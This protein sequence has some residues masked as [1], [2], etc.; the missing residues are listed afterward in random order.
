MSVKSLI[1][2][3]PER[4]HPDHSGIADSESQD[5]V[6]RELF[7]HILESEKSISTGYKPNAPDRSD[8]PAEFRSFRPN[9]MKRNILGF[10]TFACA[11]AHRD[12]NTVP[13]IDRC[14]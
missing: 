14:D 10:G 6:S 12:G 11:L 2:I 9:R 5:Y 4:A 7:V 1:V 13:A 3:S 8:G